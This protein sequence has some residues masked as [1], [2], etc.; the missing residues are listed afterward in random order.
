[1][2]VQYDGKSPSKGWYFWQKTKALA[3]TPF[4]H[5]TRKDAGRF[6]KDAGITTGILIGANLLLSVPVL[7]AAPIVPWVIGFAAIT[8]AFKFGRDA[9][10]KFGALKETAAVTNYVR[11]QENNW[12]DK[13]ARKP[14]LTRIKEGFKKKVDAIPAPA[15]KALKFAGLGLAVVGLAVGGALAL[16][17][18]GL[19]PALAPFAAA[20][21]E[22]GA[23]IGLSAT[24]ATATAI[25][26]S[27]LAVPAVGAATFAASNASM[28][29]RDPANSPFKFKKPSENAK[30]ISQGE[31]FSPG[32]NG[33]AFEFNDEAKPAAPTNDNA[34]NEARR[35]AAEERARNK[36]N[37]DNSKKF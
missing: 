20:V 11:E 35:L 32:A 10:N 27:A 5:T 14:L 25:G 16:G 4:N 37:R 13:K 15:I 36:K 26:V 23:A 18:F 3:K 28:L 19:V 12:Y 17:A 8:G 7:M 34:Q 31:V 29:R 33:K 6:A 21:V 9:W 24:A 22:A 30:P 2:G 1:M